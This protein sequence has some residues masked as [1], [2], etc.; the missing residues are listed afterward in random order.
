[1]NSKNLLATPL[2]QPL[3]KGIL[4]F[5]FV[6]AALGF[7]DA[8]Y[9]TI[10]H[11]MNVI[12]PCTIGGCETVLTSAYSTV[13]GIPISLFGAIFYLVVLIL[14]K[15]YWDSKSATAINIAAT[16]VMIGALASIVL[17]ALMVFVVKAI[18]IYCLFSDILT[19]ILCVAMWF[20]LKKARTPLPL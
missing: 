18:C 10:E 2:Q 1:M 15:V 5:L 9:L 3:S 20:I 6:I 16:L 19:I 7:I 12:P 8:T 11:Y 17:I 13:A 4:I 14:F